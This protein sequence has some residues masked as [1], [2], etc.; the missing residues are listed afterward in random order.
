M[1]VVNAVVTNLARQLAPQ[2]WGN[3]ITFE[4]IAYFK[5]GEG[6]WYDPGTGRVPR[7]PDPTLT[8]LDI[9]LDPARSIPS[10]RYYGFESFGYF[11]KT[12]VPGD[13]VFQGPTT[14]LMSCLLD[15]GDY[16]TKNAPGATL[17]YDVGGDGVSPTM[18]EM[19]AF[20]A[21]G[22]MIMYGTFPVETKDISRQV[23]NDGRI[24]F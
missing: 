4:P 15:Y 5:I 20:D 3:L 21:L 9:I 23:E 16:N 1:A 17:I 6:G 12:F 22:R 24:V 13:L 7:T 8:D 11:Q 18:W 19:G 10:R 14:L 2:M